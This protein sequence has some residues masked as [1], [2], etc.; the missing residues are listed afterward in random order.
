[1]QALYE[2]EEDNASQSGAAESTLRSPYRV[3]NNVLLISDQIGRSGTHLLE[4]LLNAYVGSLTVSFLFRR[5]CNH[6]PKA[7]G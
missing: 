2:D 4:R 1:M 3:A 6:P 7:E 5:G